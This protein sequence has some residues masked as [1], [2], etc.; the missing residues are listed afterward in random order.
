MPL[1]KQNIFIVYSRYTGENIPTGPVASIN[2]MVQALKND[3]NIN[4][5]GLSQLDTYNRYQT[6]DRPDYRLYLCQDYGNGFGY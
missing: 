1:K 6:I 2:G 4:I 3:V 5:I